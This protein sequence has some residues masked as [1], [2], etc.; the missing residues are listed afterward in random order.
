MVG[1]FAEWATI[2]SENCLS[3]KSFQIKILHGSLLAAV[4]TFIVRFSDTF[5]TYASRTCQLLAVQELGVRNR[6]VCIDLIDVNSSSQHD[7]SRAKKRL[8]R[9]SMSP[10][11]VSG[12]RKKFPCTVEGCNR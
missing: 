5:E 10:G 7:S 11:E 1:W 12:V 8:S 2:L 3:D 4:C 6:D 9:A